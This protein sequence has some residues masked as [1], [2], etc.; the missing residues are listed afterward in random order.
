MEP[1]ISFPTTSNSLKL[2]NYFWRYLI[3]KQASVRKLKEK[4]KYTFEFSN[5]AGK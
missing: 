2:A 4:V 3:F 1:F 5:A